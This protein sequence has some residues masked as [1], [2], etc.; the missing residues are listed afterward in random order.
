MPIDRRDKHR[1]E[2]VIRLVVNHVVQNVH[3]TVTIESLTE[4]LKIPDHGAQRIVTSLV[5]AGVLREVSA[6]VWSRR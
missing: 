6:G 3:Q 4:L 1:R 5:R 2:E